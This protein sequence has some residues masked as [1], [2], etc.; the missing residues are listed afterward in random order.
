MLKLHQKLKSVCLNSEYFSCIN[1]NWI[2]KLIKK[3]VLVIDCYQKSVPRWNEI[4]RNNK[5]PIPPILGGIK[6]N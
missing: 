2:R 1:E 3:Q 4:W 5:L 6:V